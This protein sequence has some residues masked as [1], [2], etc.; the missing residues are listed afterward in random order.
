ML[1]SFVHTIMYAYYGLSALGP[2]VQKY[3]WWKKYIT[4]M[5]LVSTC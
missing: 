1:N 4:Q 2:W 5:Q 3:L